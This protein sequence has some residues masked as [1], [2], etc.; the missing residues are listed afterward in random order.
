MTGISLSAAELGAPAEALAR[1]TTRPRAPDPKLLEKPKLER[2]PIPTGPVKL[3]APAGS[4]HVLLYPPKN[5]DVKRPVTVMLH[6]M[7]DEP[8]YECPHF[9]SSTTGQSW[10]V[11][12]R[13]NLRCEGGGSIW[14][15]DKRLG[16]TIE[17]GIARVDAEYAGAVD[18]E[19]GRTLI[20]FSLGAIRGMDIA[21]AGDGKYRSAILIGAKIY[22]DAKRLRKAGVQRLVLA[23]G[24]HDM[25]KWHMVA[26]TKKLIR[27][28]YPA[29]FMSM[30]KIGH[31]FPRDLGERMERA[32]AWA[33]GD[34][35]AFVPSESGELAFGGEAAEK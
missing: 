34:D 11:C 20:G 16:Q 29:A 18:G 3:D 17:D 15:A 25:M 6:G 22:P 7:C 8:E 1:S 10:L 12:P 19:Q 30:G 26:Q 5:A 27:Q 32:L 13:A 23:A 28:G 14:S 2:T 24:E 9:A 33:S 21:H 4:N 35:A 31:A